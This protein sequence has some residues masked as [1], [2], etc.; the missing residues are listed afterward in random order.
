M[1]TKKLSK[2]ITDWISKHT[3]RLLPNSLFKNEFEDRNL[4]ADIMKY[5]LTSFPSSLKNSESVGIDTTL[6]EDMKETQTILR[7][8]NELETVTRLN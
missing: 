5:Q 1:R 3:L 8:K 6:E 4:M 7:K 2:R